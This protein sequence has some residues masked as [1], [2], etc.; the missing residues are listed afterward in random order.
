MPVQLAHT[1]RNVQ[2]SIFQLLGILAQERVFV[3]PSL[4]DTCC[5]PRAS[6]GVTQFA[7]GFSYLHHQTAT[8]LSSTQSALM[9][10]AKKRLFV[11]KT[12]MDLIY[13]QIYIFLWWASD[14]YKQ[15]YQYMWSCNSFRQFSCIGQEACSIRWAKYNN[16]NWLSGVRTSLYHLRQACT[17]SCKKELIHSKIKL[18]LRNKSLARQRELWFIVGIA[19]PSRE[20]CNMALCARCVWKQ[21]NIVFSF[22][23]GLKW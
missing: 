16:I 19:Y 3:Y 9:L 11:N 22:S 4:K 13:T 17:H 7:V 5:V 10:G 23:S 21:I 15:I 2:Y 1:H 12:V 14:R 18:R 8:A 6:N 20:W